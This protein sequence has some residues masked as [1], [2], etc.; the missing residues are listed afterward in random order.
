MAAVI[1]FPSAIR[2]DHDHEEAAA[3]R[4]AR[5]ARIGARVAGCN[6]AEQLVAAK[7]AREKLAE[8][9]SEHDAIEAGVSLAK[10][11]RRKRERNDPTPPRAA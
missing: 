4:V 2:A 5:R 10:F 7:Q 3:D 8:G 9:M 6:N 1:R 11:N